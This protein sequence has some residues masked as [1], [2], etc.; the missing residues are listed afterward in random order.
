MPQINISA[1]V[2]MTQLYHWLDF[3]AREDLAATS[4]HL[5]YYSEIHT[6]IRAD[7]LSADKV[8]AHSSP[9]GKMRSDDP[10]IVNDGGDYMPHITRVLRA[11]KADN[12]LLRVAENAALQT[13]S[14]HELVAVINS[15]GAGE[16][17]SKYHGKFHYIQ[18]INA[19]SYNWYD[20]KSIMAGLKNMQMT[21]SQLNQRFLHSGLLS[22]G[23]S[24]HHIMLHID[25]AI[26]PLC[27]FFL[28]RDMVPKNTVATANGLQRIQDAHQY[29]LAFIQKKRRVVLSHDEGFSHL[30]KQL[31][32]GFHTL[33]KNRLDMQPFVVRD[34]E[35]QALRFCK[36]GNKLESVLRLIWRLERK[37]RIMVLFTI[38]FL[39]LSDSYHTVLSPDTMIM[40]TQLETWRQRAIAHESIDTL[41]ESLSTGLVLK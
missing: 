23:V 6:Y 22:A 9:I 10:V 3:F 16:S 13:A 14:R 20:I 29:L 27:V 8:Y 25:V 32:A 41:A 31:V 15:D 2:L 30:Y 1:S 26:Y 28:T 33:W 5:P 17:P 4:V 11:Q 38:R 7:R 12:Q 21:P 36:L 40:S 24:F 18:L 34:S 19:K 37:L 39:S 35:R